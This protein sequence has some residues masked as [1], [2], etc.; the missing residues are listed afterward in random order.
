M[1]MKKRSVTVIAAVALVGSAVA[2]VCMKA[3]AT[4]PNYGYTITASYNSA[5]ATNAL[6]DTSQQVTVTA[7]FGS[8]IETSGTSAQLAS[9]FTISIGGQSIPYINNATSSNALA[10]TVEQ[11]GDETLTF[12]FQ[13]SGYAAA[14]SATPFI[15]MLDGNIII[16]AANATN[17]V[18]TLPH[19]EYDGTT[20][21][22]NVTFNTLNTVIK[23]GTT[24][25]STSHTSAS[26]T[27]GASVTKTVTGISKV[28]GMI[29]FALKKNGVFVQPASG[30]AS[31]IGGVSV[32]AEAIHAHMFYSMTASGYASMI[33][34]GASGSMGNSAFSQ[35]FPDYTFSASGDTITVTQTSGTITAGDTIDFEVF[36]DGTAAD[37]SSTIFPYSYS[38]N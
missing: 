7:T 17:G 13:N 18:G 29:W 28:R 8:P 37:T 20:S 12:T 35:Y 30:T 9:D 11:T 25:S 2:F 27:T 34:N 22:G 14:A 15:K 16:A 19:V 36:E 33:A 26:G 4:T 31:A 1:L 10:Y 3:L 38:S 21:S 6:K 24:L 5:A 23:S 32:P